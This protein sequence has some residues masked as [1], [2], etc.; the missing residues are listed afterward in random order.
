MDRSGAVL[1]VLLKLS[2]TA[3]CERRKQLALSIFPNYCLFINVGNR[4]LLGE[5]HPYCAANQKRNEMMQALFQ[6]LYFLWMAFL[7]GTGCGCFQLGL[8]GA[9]A[10]VMAADIVLRVDRDSFS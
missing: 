8:S 6:F 4:L 5:F 2:A 7:L 1:S 3:L 10:L 9:V